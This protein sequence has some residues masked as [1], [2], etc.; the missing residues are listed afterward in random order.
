IGI[1]GLSSGAR[2]REWRTVKHL[3]LLLPAAAALLVV[4]GYAI[5]VRVGPGLCPALL[6]FGGG[7]M[8]AVELGLRR[9]RQ[10][11]S[12]RNPLLR[13]S[14]LRRTQAR[15][16]PVMGSPNSGRRWSMQK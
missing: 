14:R 3:R 6:C 11:G 12:S 15:H 13:T 4:T 10:P 2:S 8:F 5:W 16:P 9:R 1:L 7:L